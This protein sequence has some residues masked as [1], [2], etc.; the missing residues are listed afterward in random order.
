M[1]CPKCGNQLPDGAKFCSSCGSPVNEQPVTPAMPVEP[2]MSAIPTMITEPV[3]AEQPVIAE[4]PVVPEQPV[5]PEQPFAPAFMPEQP[6]PENMGM[7]ATAPVKKSK[8]PLFIGLGIGVLVI[9]IIAI[10]LVLIF[11]G[12]D[13][14]DKKKTPAAAT[15]AETTTTEISTEEE[16]T[17]EEA[18]D[19][20]SPDIDYSDATD[21]V[22]EFFA[23]LEYMDYD[24]C[25]EYLYP[26]FAS[27]IEDYADMGADDY[28][29]AYSY[30]YY[31]GNG[32]FIDYKVKNAKED[33][34]TNF[35][36]FEDNISGYSDYE[37]PSAFATCEVEFTYN[38][39][40]SSI[41]VNLGY[42]NG[43]FYIYDLTDLELDIEPDTEPESDTTA[44]SDMATIIESR[45][46]D[47]LY[48]YSIEEGDYEGTL[49]NGV[50]GYTIKMP[51]GW[52]G[53]ENAANGYTYYYAPSGET[54]FCL[55]SDTSFGTTDVVSYLTEFC[56]SLV[57]SDI[58]VINLGKL[59]TPY[60]NG[61]YVVGM[62]TLTDDTDI[63]VVAYMI[64]DTTASTIHC[65]SVYTTDVAGAEA[66]VAEY[67]A[68]SLIPQ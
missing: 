63:Y 55:L 17:T 6:M 31:D 32:S 15:D 65:V 58:T 24:E 68:A 29:D 5:M 49:A 30:I 37:K 26:G 43:K 45:I 46:N 35:F 48:D 66:V 14:D 36:V 39:Q 57:E 16:T 52:T 60:A 56:T 22:K 19:I 41:V 54:S 34:G 33:D 1:F 28:L 4:Q 18:T 8:A 67:V 51:D 38:D 61:Y 44:T 25:A 10:I 64:T 50:G 59:S 21:I 2:V 20:V 62:Q 40:K 12:D 13:D 42:T 11:S 27:F 23:T 3:V 7:S 9:A 53:Q 47:S